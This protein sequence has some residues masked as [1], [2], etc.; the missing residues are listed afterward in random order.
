M[1]SSCGNCIATCFLLP[2]GAL[3]G[4]AWQ[5]GHHCSLLASSWTSGCRGSPTNFLMEEGF[6]D[7]RVRL[8]C[9][10]LGSCAFGMYKK[11]LHETF[12]VAVT[13]LCNSQNFVLKEFRVFK[14]TISNIFMALIA[15]MC[16]YTIKGKHMND[17]SL[18]PHFFF[19]LQLNKGPD[20]VLVVLGIGRKSDYEYIWYPA[21]LLI[22]Y[23]FILFVFSYFFELM[24]YYLIS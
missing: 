1:W 20:C 14:Y 21:S 15:T 12:N 3:S 23:P 17:P 5:K 10:S 13:N 2:L 16:S 19:L 8:L 4:R 22:K 11:T 24:Q 6:S 18:L 7:F 9:I